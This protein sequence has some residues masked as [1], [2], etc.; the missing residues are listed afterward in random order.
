MAGKNGHYE[1]PRRKAAIRFEGTAYDGAEVVCRLDVPLQMFLDFQRMA[2]RTDDPEVLE[3]TFRR[4]GD[5]VLESWNL[6][7]GGKEVPATADG[8]LRQ[9][10]AFAMLILSKWMESI[11]AAPDPL[12]AP[13]PVN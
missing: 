3:Q 9:P 11:G 10:P 6:S 12:V 5:E 8:F 1:V 4:F 13:V 7:E 2:A